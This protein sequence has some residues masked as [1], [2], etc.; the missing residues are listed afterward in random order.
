MNVVRTVFA[1]TITA[2]TAGTWAAEPA[3]YRCERLHRSGVPN[4]LLNDMNDLGTAVGTLNVAD[5]GWH[6]AIWRERKAEVL[7]YVAGHEGAMTQLWAISADGDMVG[8]LSDDS[9]ILP[10]RW[11]AGVGAPLPLLADASRKEGEAYAL[12]GRGRVVGY[13]VNAAGHAHATLWKNGKVIDLGALAGPHGARK[14][15]SFAVAINA[16]GMVAG[17]SV[18]P[19]GWFHAVQWTDG[20]PGSLVDLGATAF[21]AESMARSVNR[22]KVV[23][24]SSSM[25]LNAEPLRPIGWIDGVAFDLK[26][27]ANATNSEATDIN[28]AGTVVGLASAGS[29]RVALVWPHYLD[30]PIDLNTR[31][32]ARGC[33]D[34]G[35]HPVPL[36]AAWAINNHGQILVT[37]RNEFSGP[38]A[39]RLTPVSER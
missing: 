10:V 1:L 15:D 6:P 20:T 35:G 16:S 39:L 14:T 3:T 9:V 24:G 29:E 33:H 23:V 38:A 37:G 34:A 21:G 11:T 19:D 32:D 2:A 25:D 8:S 26:P 7:P 13:S 17:L 5:D 18:G 30:E 28:D 36:E 31:L 27:P 4:A 12:N 22:H